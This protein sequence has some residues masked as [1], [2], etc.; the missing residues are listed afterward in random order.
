MLRKTPMTFRFVSELPRRQKKS[1]KNRYVHY[2]FFDGNEKK[3][4][5]LLARGDEQALFLR[6][7]S[8]AARSRFAAVLFREALD[9]LLELGS[10][11]PDQAL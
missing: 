9:P 7:V 11:M 6:V 10:E 2:A 4:E 5:S 8:P 3:I 1:K